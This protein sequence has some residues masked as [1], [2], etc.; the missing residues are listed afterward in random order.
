MIFPNVSIFSVFVI[1]IITPLI[2][3]DGDFVCCCVIL[4]MQHALDTRL[5]FYKWRYEYLLNSRDHM[6]MM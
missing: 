4:E 5:P 1:F 2:L 3:G 6:A